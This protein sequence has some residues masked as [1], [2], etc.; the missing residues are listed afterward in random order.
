MEDISTL[1]QVI[2][3]PIGLRLVIEAAGVLLDAEE[4]HL[5]SYS[6]SI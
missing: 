5:P 3:P 1:T 4:E 6:V 2:K